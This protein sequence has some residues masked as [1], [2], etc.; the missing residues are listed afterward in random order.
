MHAVHIQALSNEEGLPGIIIDGY[1][2]VLNLRYGVNI[3][4]IMKVRN[5]STLTWV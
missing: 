2:G 3:L 4:H 1:E 5:R